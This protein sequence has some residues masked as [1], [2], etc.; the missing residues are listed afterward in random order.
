MKAV[1]ATTPGGPEVLS[2]AD[3]PDPQPGPGEV[4][5]AIVA[6]AV[7]RAAGGLSGGPKS[8]AEPCSVSSSRPS[9]ARSTDTDPGRPPVARTSAL[10]CTTSR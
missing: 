8:D 4:A 2:L 9:R 10:F 5:I 6:S 1:L 7:N 3:L